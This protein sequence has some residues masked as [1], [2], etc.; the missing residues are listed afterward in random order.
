[1]ND[2]EL[3][4]L[5]SG[6]G[7]NIGGCG[8][9]YISAL[10]ERGLPAP[11][12]ARAD[13]DSIYVF[14]TADGNFQIEYTITGTVA[15]DPTDLDLSGVPD[16]VEQ[17]G[18]SFERSWATEVDSLGFAAPDLG[19]G[20]YHVSLRYNGSLFGYLREAFGWPGGT[21]I[22]V[23]R[24]MRLF[25]PAEPES[26]L[27]ACATNL[28]LATIAH[29][30][31]H[32]VQFAAGWNLFLSTEWNEL[33][34]TWIEDLVYDDSNDYYRYL[35]LPL[36]TFNS[37]TR[38]VLVGYYERC[39]WHHFLSE[40]YGSGFLVDLEQRIGANP[41]L[42]V[43]RHYPLIAAGRS[44]DWNE[45]WGDYTVANYLS[46]TRAVPGMGFEEAADYPLS[47]VE[48]LPEIPTD[49]SIAAS[50]EEMAMRFY[51][52]DSAGSGTNGRVQVS[53][54]GN[55]AMAWTV[56]VVF[57]RAGLTEVVDV[58][59]VA[60][61]GTATPP[62]KIEDFDRVSI[63]V[64]NAQV[65]LGAAAGAGGYTLDVGVRAVPV[66]EGTIGGLKGRFRRGR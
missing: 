60:G 45:L 49:S 58:S 32:A 6:T 22:V 30:F 17:V 19:G 64:G 33:D 37:P 59:V 47:V 62:H 23:H 57:Q 21:T 14:H 15:V 31:K 5:F 40:N 26:E 34:A 36:S 46:A 12:L 52:F 61:E 65:P 27:Q 50:L 51:E 43:Q 24:D 42:A 25:C 28:L 39:T 11:E 56:R 18:A 44:I 10:R 55:A 3:M 2:S 29:E 16:Y 7:D 4:Q 20:R 13:A 38:S 9:A 54:S 63:L 53:F 66:D 35:E 1:M 48:V 8:T 41:Y